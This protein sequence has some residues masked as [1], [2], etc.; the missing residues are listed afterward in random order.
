MKKHDLER[1][2]CALCAAGQVQD[3]NWGQ[4]SLSPLSVPAGGNPYW[5]AWPLEAQ[6]DGPWGF[7][8][9]PLAA[10]GW[11]ALASSHPLPASTSS[12]L[13]DTR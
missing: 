13:P 1:L 10:L 9:A 7:A 8:V 5:A 2:F 4:A 3:K 6:V 11:N 12:L